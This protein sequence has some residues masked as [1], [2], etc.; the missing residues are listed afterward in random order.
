LKTEPHVA[1]CH[2]GLGQAL[3]MQG[4]L[5][6]AAQSCQKAAQIQPGEPAFRYHLHCA[7]RRLELEPRL[8]ALLGGKEKLAA[9]EHILVIDLCIGKRLYASAVRLYREAFAADSQLA[10]HPFS[11]ARGNA[12]W[13]AVLAAAGEGDESAQLG[14]AE[15]S[16]L[17]AQALAWLRA[18]LSI[19]R[20]QLE[21]EP[22]KARGAVF[23]I[24]APLEHDPNL[25]A[26]RDEKALARLPDSERRDWRGFWTDVAALLAKARGEKK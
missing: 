24:I 22:A 6:E 8:D 26:L 20:R 4:K 11:P 13:V 17:R 10:K 3:A 1:G 25:S 19:W 14:A 12:A 7:K 5:A 9:G 23:A 18:E 16:R 2:D 15:R 21:Q